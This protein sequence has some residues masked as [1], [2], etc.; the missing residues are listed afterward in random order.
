MTKIAAV[1]PK[2]AV[3]AFKALGLEVVSVETAEQASK[4]VF[5]LAEAGCQVIFITE[6]EAEKIP[7]TI[8]RY[9]TSPT[10]AIIPIPGAT[11]ATGFGM[12]A[13]RANVEKAVGADI[14]NIGGDAQ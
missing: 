7:E 9:K 8:S 12:R 3:L 4:A 6:R 10:P 13:V 1:G 2:D 5:D 11:G 14:L